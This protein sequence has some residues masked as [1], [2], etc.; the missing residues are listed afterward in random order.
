MFDYALLSKIILG[1]RDWL[2]PA[3]LIS[4]FALVFIWSSYRRAVLDTGVK[5]LA[6]VLKGLGIVLLAICLVEP[7]W[8]GTRARPG[9]NLFAILADHSASLKTSDSKAA[10]SRGEELA[11]LVA[12]SEQLPGKKTTNWQTRLEQDFDVRRYLFDTRLN[13]V[14]EFASLTFD[15]HAT[16]LQTS[17]TSL[18][19][20][21]Q[22]RP[23]A[24]ALLLTDGNA[25][26]LINGK[27][28]TTGLPPIYPVVMGSQD[29]LADIRIDNVSTSQTSFEDAPVTVR[30]DA[31]STGYAGRELIAE[32]LDADKKVIAT[33]KQTVAD[34]ETL[35]STFRFR[36]KPT[37]RGVTFYTLRVSASDETAQFADPSQ[38]K[39]ATIRNN[40]QLIQVD[41]GTRPHRILYVTGRPN[42]EFKFLRRAMEGDDLVDLV[43]LV[44][45][46]RREPKF[47][48]RSR[49]GENSNPLFRGF[50]DGNDDD[51]ESYDQPVLIR[52]NTRDDVELRDGF[53]KTEAELYQF[54]AVIVDDLEAAFFTGDQKLLLDKY[55]SR[56][57]GGFMMLGGQESFRN[58]GYLRT[59]IGKMLPVYLD[60]PAAPLIDTEYEYLLTREG[61][62]QPWVRLRK[63]ETEEAQR[64][65]EMP[66]FKT[67]NRVTS[68]KPGATV[69]AAVKDAKGMEFPALVTHRYGKG[70]VAAL[71]IA[72]FW[73]WRLAEDRPAVAT[74]G[75][76]V[77]KSDQSKAWRQ[78]MR[79]LV[80]DVPQR[81]D[82]SVV[83]QPKTGPTAVKLEVR[84][85]NAEFLPLDNA[86]AKITINPPGGGAPVVLEAEESTREPGL[87]ET[88]Y[89]ARTSGA[90]Q[91]TVNVTDE[92][93]KYSGTETT[94][95]TSNLQQREF[96]RINPNRA[97]LTDLA[98]Q[99]GG[100][101]I[102]A[103]E[104][105]QFVAGLASRKVPLT[106]EWTT[107]LWHQPWIFMLAIGCLVSEWGLRRWKGLP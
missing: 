27:L 98:T 12:V 66:P 26:D 92:D 24:G 21:F 36:V 51:T 43:G 77:E 90:F 76:P 5:T 47:D 103:D 8:S 56:R 31:R 74:A 73:R 4:A 35:P 14:A 93:E 101:V 97:L 99:T 87:Y 19:E 63:T 78:M 69:M 81:I 53:P 6:A 16:S 100:E 10:K 64:V 96:A 80:A 2:M 30:M 37:Q 28:D 29:G 67:I 62:L 79:W 3:M 65:T 106:E 48:F 58:G 84:V 39:E 46:A 107:P 82:I 71:T 33:K 83:P 13:N 105:D 41:R 7:L 86:L 52:I 104:L 25:T 32:L 61:K 20:R 55:V 22:E 42:W 11:E 1:D 60:R 15:G 88:D 70:R 50:K 9:A 68:I 89:V 49:R 17:L 23:L 72:D 45:I 57:G 34:D 44:R 18:K 38:S 95:W 75:Q 40:V 91:A 102:E 59:P 54:D 85:R 94:G